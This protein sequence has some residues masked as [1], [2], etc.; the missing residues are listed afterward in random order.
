MKNRIIIGCLFFIITNLSAQT[1]KTTSLEPNYETLSI[2]YVASKLKSPGSAQLV[3]YAGVADTR[4]MLTKAGFKLS[5]CTK[6]TRVVVDSQNGFG[7]LIRGFYFVFFKNGQP[8]HLED[9]ESLKSGAGYGNMT[10]M[11][12]V[13]LGLN[14][15]DCSE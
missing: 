6:V 11:L 1:K 4:E 10:N 5:E 9:A 12:N 14:N 13:T 2:N 15:C 3:D 8:C 7:A